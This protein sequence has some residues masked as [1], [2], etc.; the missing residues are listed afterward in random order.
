MDVCIFTHEDTRE[1]VPLFEDIYTISPDMI[2]YAQSEVV[3]D[4]LF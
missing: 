1:I 2:V 3:L 4:D